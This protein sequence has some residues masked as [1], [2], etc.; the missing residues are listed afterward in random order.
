MIVTCFD[1]G[2]RIHIDGAIAIPL[3]GKRIF[4]CRRCYQESLSSI[5]NPVAYYVVDRLGRVRLIKK[6]KNLFIP[7]LISMSKNNPR[8]KTEKAGNILGGL[9]ILAIPIGIGLIAWLYGKSKE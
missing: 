7:L 6:R 9:G 8:T 1:C 5:R 4:V 3:N 2:R